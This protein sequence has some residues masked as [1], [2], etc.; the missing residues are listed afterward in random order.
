VP[1]G[2]DIPL[3][4]QI[5]KWRRQI[6]I[7]HVE[8]CAETELTDFDQTRLPRNQSEGDMPQMAFV[9]GCDPAEC[10]LRRLGIADE[11][12]TPPSG[13]GRVHF[14]RGQTGNVIPGGNTV[15]NTYT[16]WQ[17][18]K[19]LLK[20]DIIFNACE[21][22]VYDRNL[23]DGGTAYSAMKE[24]LDKGGRLFA[25]HFHYNWFAPPTG[26][27][28]FQS[29]IEWKKVEE[30]DTYKTFFV[31]TGFPKGEAYA[32]W[33]QANGITPSF[34]EIPLED[35]RFNMDRITEKGTRWIYGAAD[36]DAGA[37]AS[38][39][40]YVSFNTPVN[41]PSNR[42]CGRAV[43]SDVHLAGSGR[44]IFPAYCSGAAAIHE[45]NERALEFLFFD[46]SSCVQDEGEDP[47]HP[48]N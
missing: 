28:D 19:N 26:P 8:A 2:E 31:D 25:T 20:Y 33:L 46:L 15:P 22:N 7:P 37:D 27:A 36:V 14:Y 23:E 47:V 41:E 17:D 38:L 12:F 39:P 40:V 9:S 35:L 5:G 44:G 45:T 4:M 11:E 3:V 48:P 34:G 18:A 29:V 24:Y 30:Q 10:F 1:A 16:W 32:E 13:P 42:Q 43:F 6:V 21:C